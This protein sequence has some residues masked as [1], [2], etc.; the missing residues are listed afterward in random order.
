M[1][2]CLPQYLPLRPCLLRC[3]VQHLYLLP[4]HLHP[5]LQRQLH[6]S[7]NPNHASIREGKRR[8]E[9]ARTLQ[10]QS[11]PSKK[12]QQQKQTPTPKQS[13]KPATKPKEKP[14]APISTPRQPSI[15]NQYR[16]QVRLFDGRSVRSSFTPT[17]TIRA[18]IR[19]WLDSQMDEKSPY[20][21]KH[22]LTPLPNRTLTLTDEETPLAELGLGSS[23]NLV[24]IPIQ[25]YTEAYS[26]TASSLPVRAVSSAYGLVS[27]AV[28]TATGL[29]GSFFGYGPTPA[30]ETEQPAPTPAPASNGR[31]PR[32]GPII[33]TL[34][35]Q[36][37]ERDD[38]AFYNG[39][40]LN[41]QPRND[42]DRR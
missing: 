3:L 1:R 37:N 13:P 17:Q 4:L 25:S 31:R 14:S 39:N 23:A 20:N 19:P 15:P 8:V 24:M 2:L 26:A 36:Q 18:D 7:P 11:P 42:G 34:R 12:L 40:Q 10:P 9:D 30:A 16:L 32:T 38:R 28:G 35:D 5:P 29:V 21:L 33:R 27:S 41:F 6:L 22:I